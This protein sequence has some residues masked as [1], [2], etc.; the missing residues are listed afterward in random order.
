VSCQGDKVGM[1]AGSLLVDTGLREQPSLTL[2][3]GCRV[4]G[5][6]Q[7]EPSN[8]TFNL[9]ISGDRATTITVKSRHPGFAVKAAKVTEGPFNATLE[10]PTPD[11][12]FPITVRVNNRQIP[13]DARSAAGK[14]IIQS[15]D[16]RE[17]SK[18]IPLLGFGKINKVPAN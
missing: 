5:T 7:V 6:L 12:S 3:W 13:D 15:N 4:P 18:E 1:H 16:P 2:S 11:G 8:P 17:P 10:R 14:L 9:R